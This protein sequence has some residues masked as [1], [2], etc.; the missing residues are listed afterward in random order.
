MG[1]SKPLTLPQLAG[2]IVKAG[3]PLT[4]AS[5][6]ATLDL[7]LEEASAVALTPGLRSS[8]EALCAPQ[9]RLTL[10]DHAA[11]RRHAFFI[12][13]SVAAQ[14]T[15]KGAVVGLSSPFTTDELRGSLVKKATSTV[16]AEPL[17][18]S[19]L[20][21]DALAGV[22]R[23]KGRLVERRSRPEANTL[24]ASV[25]LI[26]ELAHVGAL[27]I[28][29]QEVLLTPAFKPLL[30]SMMAQEM[31]SL[32][33]VT[34]GGPHGAFSE[35]VHAL[36]VGPEGRRLTGTDLTVA[37]RTATAFVALE[38]EQARRWATYFV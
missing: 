14:V 26:D 35:P 32:E 2:T 33:L 23:Q 34:A 4:D 10:I 5:P 30:A 6:F 19:I 25:E 22:F 13:G 3:L 12:K 38:A 21:L 8:L 28:K 9:R 11:R 37:G 20:L 18:I 24:V 15:G 29:G 27:T 16:R 7:E 36:L 1:E 17:A 31:I